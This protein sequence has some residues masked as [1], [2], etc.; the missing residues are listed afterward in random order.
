MTVGAGWK[1]PVIVPLGEGD[2]TDTGLLS[3]TLT[4]RHRVK[5]S[6]ITFFYKPFQE[7]S[8]NYDYRLSGF[9]K[10]RLVVGDT[11]EE[12]DMI[13]DYF[14]FGDRVGLVCRMP[15]VSDFIVDR[16]QNVYLIFESPVKLTSGIFTKY[17]ITIQL[18]TTMESNT[19]FSKNTRS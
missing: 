1:I 12:Y 2:V 14:I 13:H 3:Y 15:D 6:D 5:L 8:V 17:G 4:T 16:G 11:R 18:N 9:I 7:G 19:I 10:V